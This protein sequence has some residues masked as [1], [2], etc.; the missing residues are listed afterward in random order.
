MRK[1][2]ST[3]RVRRK[4]IVACLPAPFFLWI[5]RAATIFYGKLVLLPQSPA[6]LRASWERVLHQS[7]EFEQR[8]CPVLAFQRRGLLG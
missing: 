1:V 7:V 4:Q 6:F 3:H 2:K 5:L 8:A